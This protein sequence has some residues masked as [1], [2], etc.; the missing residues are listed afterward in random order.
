MSHDRIIRS[1]L[2]AAV[3]LHVIG[4]MVFAPPAIGF[5]GLKL[6]LAGPRYYLAQVAFT[7]AMFGGVYAWL[8]SRP[9]IDRSLVALGAI[10]KLGFFLLALGYALAGDLPT[11]AIPQAAPDLAFASIF[12]WWLRATRAR[13]PSARAVAEA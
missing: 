8:A 10:G 4:L 2:W 7:I 11:S 5:T 9:T 13:S 3:V 1:V 12:L 6:P